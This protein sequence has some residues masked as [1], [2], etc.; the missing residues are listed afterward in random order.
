MTWRKSQQS[1]LGGTMATLRKRG[2]KN[3]KAKSRPVA[4]KKAS[5][6]KP[7]Q[8]PQSL[9]RELAEVVEQQAAT[10]EILRMIAKCSGRSPSGARC[11]RRKR[12]ALMRCQG[13][14]DISRRERSHSPRGSLRRFARR[15]RNTRPTT[16]TSPAG[17]AMVDRQTV[18]IRD[19]AAVVDSEYPGYQESMRAVSDI[20]RPWLCRCCATGFPSARF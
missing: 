12:G 2:T 16:A 19:L 10:G 14:A 5:S 15:V 13:C 7:A 8:T 18:H 3:T 1:A 6:K 20:E 17:R 9:R 4:A 11:D